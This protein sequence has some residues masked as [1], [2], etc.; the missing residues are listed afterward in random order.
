[1]KNLSK[2]HNKHNFSPVETKEGTEYICDFCGKNEDDW[3]A[4]MKAKGYSDKELNRFQ[5]QN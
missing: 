3:Y 4:E 1:M 5:V 2:V